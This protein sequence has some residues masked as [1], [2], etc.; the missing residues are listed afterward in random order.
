MSASTT[1]SRR[2]VLATGAASALL[3]KGAS[4]QSGPLRIIFPFSGG[5]SGDALCRLMADAMGRTLGETIIVEPRPGAGGQ[6]GVRSVT[7]G[8]ADGRQLLITPFGPISI[9]PIV[10]PNLPYDPFRDLAPVT[11]LTT[12]DFAIAVHPQ[13]PVKTMPELVAWMKDDPKRATYGS[14]GAGTLPHFFGALLGSA[15]GVPMQHAAYRGS[16]ASLTDLA[17]G[18]V[19]TVITTTSD[20]IQLARAGSIRVI[21]VS[22][23]ARSP[24]LPDVPTFKEGGIEIEGSGWYA[25]YAKAGTPAPL[26][27]KYNEAAV[28]ALKQPVLRE[29]I[30]TLAMVPTGTTPEELAAI[31]KRDYEHWIPA[32][33][34]S[35]FK[36]T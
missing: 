4:A 16:S 30:E 12:F 33:K 32:V 28:A 17:A 22:G 29:R 13:T 24:F 6:V 36:P 27:A 18:Q 23:A 3:P 20:F 2:A 10:F 21:A 8:A 25:M 35:G 15:V 9:H 5:G 7:D 34:A 31:Q 11:Q 19:P 1:L 26:L 14:P